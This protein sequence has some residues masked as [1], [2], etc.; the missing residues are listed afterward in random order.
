MNNFAK[1]LLKSGCILGCR[2][3]QDVAYAGQHEGAERVVDHRFVVDRHQ[4][5]GDALGDRP[6]PRAAA[7]SEDDAAHVRP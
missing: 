1:Q 4:L 3:Q 5:L 7:A 2:D 6:Q